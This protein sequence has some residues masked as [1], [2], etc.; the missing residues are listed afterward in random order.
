[1]TKIKLLK[2]ELKT[3]ALEIRSLKSTRKSVPNGYVSGLF[4][5]QDTFRHMH[6]AYCLL[7]GKTYEQ[8]EQKTRDGNAPSTNEY[9]RYMTQYKEVIDETL[10]IGG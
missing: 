1:M 3:R 4:A 7:R 6:I 5:K 9:E 2:A 8:I 10:C